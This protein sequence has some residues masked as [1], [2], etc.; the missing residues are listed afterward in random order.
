MQIITVRRK[1][2]GINVLRVIERVVKI[3]YIVRTLAV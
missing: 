3:E 2:I 1:K